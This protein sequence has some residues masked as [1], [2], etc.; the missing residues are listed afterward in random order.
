VRRAAL[1]SYEWKDRSRHQLRN[2]LQ[3]KSTIYAA[4][5]CGCNPG[6]PDGPHVNPR[7]EVY[8]S[9]PWTTPFLENLVWFA[10]FALGG[11]LF[12]QFSIW[13]AAAYVAYSVNCM[14][15]L[16]PMLV[17]THCSYYGR[18]C[19]SGQGRIAGFLFSRAEPAPFAQSFKYARLAAP[20]FLAPLV[21]GVILSALHFTWARVGLTVG[22]GALALGATRAI[23]C[24]L[25]CPHCGQRSVCPAFQKAQR[26]SIP[27]S[28]SG[29]V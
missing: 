12:A 4:A 15:V 16:M 10:V 5:I 24:G 2:R 28:D 29:V 13:A 19:H 9:Y 3:L 22:F 21:A 8:H 25:G 18:T 17:C 1:T 6:I 27:S 7:A 26:T 14:Y 11:F 23:T 20:V